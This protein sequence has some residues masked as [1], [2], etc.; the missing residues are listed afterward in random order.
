MFT[1]DHLKRSRVS[2]EESHFPS[3]FYV[4]VGLFADAKIKTE[5]GEFLMLKP[6]SGLTTKSHLAV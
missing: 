4:Y 3:F 6:K 2:V 1:S 5:R